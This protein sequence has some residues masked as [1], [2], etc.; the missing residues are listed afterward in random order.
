MGSVTSCTS[1]VA[2]Q[3]EPAMPRRELADGLQK[4]VERAEDSQ[5]SAARR[6]AAQHIAKAMNEDSQELNLSGLGLKTLPYEI[7]HL[8]RLQ[9]LD[10]SGNALTSIP[11]RFFSM[12]N[13]RELDL[14]RNQLTQL[15]FPEN[16]SGRLEKLS[17]YKNQITELPPNLSALDNLTYL[18]ISGNPLKTL[19][20]GYGQLPQLRS[21]MAFDLSCALPVEICFLSSLN[22][23]NGKTLIRR[24]MNSTWQDGLVRWVNAASQQEKIERNAVARKMVRA[25]E[26]KML[27]I[28]TGV[29]LDLHGHGLSSLP[30]GIGE[31][32]NVTHLN[33]SANRLA[34]L[35]PEIVELDQLRELDLSNNRF[36]EIPGVTKHFTELHNLNISGNHLSNLPPSL[37]IGAPLYLEQHAYRRR[38]KGPLQSEEAQRMNSKERPSMK[39]LRRAL[40]DSISKQSGSCCVK[41]KKAADLLRPLVEHGQVRAVLLTWFDDETGEGKLDVSNHTACLVSWRDG[42]FVVDTTCGQDGGEDLYVGPPEEW[43]K[44]I[45]ALQKDKVYSPRMEILPKP[46]GETAIALRV[47]ERFAEAFGPSEKE[48]QIIESR[49]GLSTNGTSRGLL[50]PQPARGLPRHPPELPPSLTLDANAE[51]VHEGA[52]K[53][54]QQKG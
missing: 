49:N 48:R 10:A 40:A 41:T 12:P 23:L 42:D 50:S 3:V 32:D 39:I 5:E 34:D 37:S 35:P 27:G 51:E 38:Q 29:E 47:A 30:P 28:N 15:D 44:Q 14:S 21:L 52:A 13:L 1:S 17:I 26:A 16:A 43:Y 9:K 54:K 24:E 33:L 2:A 8:Q 31:L 7:A 11:K 45:M 4:W 6:A 25:C 18:D 20:L 22:S 36:E 19:A 46:L 53:E